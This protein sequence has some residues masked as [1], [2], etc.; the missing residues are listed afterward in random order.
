[1][2]ANASR[3]LGVVAERCVSIS[4]VEL[5]VDSAGADELRFGWLKMVLGFSGGWGANGFSRYVA[6]VGMSGSGG[7]EVTGESKDRGGRD[8][9]DVATDGDD[10]EE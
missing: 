9:A 2:L 6:L 10:E 5:I 8:G 3:L 7:V 1:M 4:G